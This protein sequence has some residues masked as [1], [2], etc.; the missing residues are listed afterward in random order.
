MKNVTVALKD[1]VA[2]WVRVRATEQNK[3]VSRFLGEMLDRQ[4]LN[5]EDYQE[6]MTRF[7]SRQP[8]RIND[9]DSYPHRDDLYDRPLL[10]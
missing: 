5:E 10:R 4:M 3:S 1:D 9:S 2:R 8:S 6:A 7:L